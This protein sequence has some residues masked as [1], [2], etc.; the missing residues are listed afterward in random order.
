VADSG[1]Y[2]RR[3][4]EEEL[5]AAE[6]ASDPAVASIH[7]DLARRYGEIVERRLRPALVHV[8]K[9]ALMSGFNGA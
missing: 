2:Y 4:I 3:R 5:A 9:R 7:L 6:R 8:E 1:N